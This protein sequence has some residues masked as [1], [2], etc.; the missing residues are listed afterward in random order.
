MPPKKT[1]QP[2]HVCV[3]DAVED[4]RTLVDVLARALS[5]VDGRVLRLPS[6]RAIAMGWIR[7]ALD[8]YR[9][10][11]VDQAQPNP[12]TLRREVWLIAANAALWLALDEAERDPE[13][14]EDGP[15]AQELDALLEALEAGRPTRDPRQP[16]PRKKMPPP[17]LVGPASAAFPEGSKIRRGGKA[18][19]VSDG[20]R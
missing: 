15:L 4:T 2:F 9:R 17:R 19:V 18:F 7:T 12:A 1:Q 14:K 3:A 6:E 16:P 11:V 8:S 5:V 20:K 13:G 10:T